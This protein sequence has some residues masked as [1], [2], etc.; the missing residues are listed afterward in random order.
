M[1]LPPNSYGRGRAFRAQV[2]LSFQYLVNPREEQ[3]HRNN[4]SFYSKNDRDCGVMMPDVCTSNCFNRVGGCSP[5]GK[6]GH[7]VDVV[8]V[9]SSHRRV[10]T[11][12]YEETTAICNMG[13]HLT[14]RINRMYAVRSNWFQG[15][16]DCGGTA[17][18]PINLAASTHAVV[19]VRNIMSHFNLP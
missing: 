12:K 18:S 1:D 3:C 19:E 14:R 6:V 15:F 9:Y 13:L 16:P 10:C 7:T 8:F 2:R 5:G 17:Q 4:L 11:L